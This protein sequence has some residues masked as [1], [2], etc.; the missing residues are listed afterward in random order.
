ML[1]P[2]CSAGVTVGFAQISYT[3]EEGSESQS[4][5]AVLT[6]MA[7]RIVTVN[8]ST[9]EGIAQGEYLLHVFIP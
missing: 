7:Q 5:C 8:L 4:V 1:V 6:G 2:V 9:V 3:V